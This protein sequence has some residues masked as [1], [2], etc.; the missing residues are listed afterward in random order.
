MTNIISNVVEGSIKNWSTLVFYEL[1]EPEFQRAWGY[2]KL[3]KGC[4]KVKRKVE[5]Q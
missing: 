5:N 3:C 1:F 2:C 4:K